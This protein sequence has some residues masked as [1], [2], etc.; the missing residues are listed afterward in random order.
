MDFRFTTEYPHTEELVSFL[1]G[2]RL[3][4]PKESY[5]DFLD[6][7]DKSYRELQKEKKRAIVCIRGKELVGSIIYQRHKEHH[8]LLELKNLTIE[9]MARGRYIASFLLRNA[10]VEG[11]RDFHSTHIICDAKKDNL[12]IYRFLTKHAYRRVATSDLYRFGAGLDNVYFKS[13]PIIKNVA[14]A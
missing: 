7:A 11:A 9:P 12:S 13:I 5:P 4:I 1:M 14:L 3:W 6:W 8:D 2:P 10:E